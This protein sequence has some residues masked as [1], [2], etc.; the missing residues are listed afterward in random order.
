MTSPA[1]GDPTGPSQVRNWGTRVNPDQLPILWRDRAETLGPYSPAAATAY[2]EAAE[3]LAAA[4]EHYGGA[5]LTLQEAS[6]ESG[7]SVDHLARLIRQGR[8]E[9][10]GEKGAPRIRRRDLPRKA[11]DVAAR[12]TRSYD[13]VTDARKLADRQKGG[14]NGLS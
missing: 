7:L 10:A 13:V 1:I 8:I 3:E 6:S 11:H 4:L 5:T 2:R 14:P 9:N 12:G